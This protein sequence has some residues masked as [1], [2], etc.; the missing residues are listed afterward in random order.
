MDLKYV[1]QEFEFDQIET[2]ISK[3]D[4]DNLYLLI[5]SNERI[6]LNNDDIFNYHD[7]FFN[8]RIFPQFKEEKLL[9]IESFVK[10]VKKKFI[11]SKEK[12][13]H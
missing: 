1:F 4:S 11:E 5:P 3:L 10:I 9:E 12:N 7:M 13:Y 8:N 6:S 2:F